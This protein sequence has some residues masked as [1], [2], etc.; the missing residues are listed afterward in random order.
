MQWNGRTLSERSIG[1]RKEK[2]KKEPNTS[3]KNRVLAVMVA[4]EVVQGWYVIQGFIP[5]STCTAKLSEE[6]LNL[7]RIG[8]TEQF[9]FLERKVNGVKRSFFDKD[10]IS[11]SQDNLS[12]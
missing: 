6:E 2:G 12:L 5:P 3:E 10:P 9:S 8:W 7:K 1:P 4:C 11:L